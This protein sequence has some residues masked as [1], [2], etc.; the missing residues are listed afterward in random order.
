ME[1]REIRSLVALAE[2]ESIARTAQAV[3]LTPAAVHKQIKNLEAELGI[4]LYEKVGRGVRLTPPALAILPHLKELLARYDGVLSVTSDWKGLGQGQLRIGANPA[5]SGFLIPRLLRAF[6]EAWPEVTPVLEVEG[7]ATLL[8]NITNRSLDLAV[9]IWSDEDLAGV[10]HTMRWEYEVVAVSHRPFPSGTRLRALS[11]EPFVRLPPSTFLGRWVDAYLTRHGCQP[12]ETMYVS[13][14]HT[15][16]SL[17]RAGLGVG[18]LPR[19]AV[20]GEI[21]SKALHVIPVKEPR[22][23]G[24]LDLIT[25]KGGYVP[26]SVE[27]FIALARREGAGEF[28]RLVP[29]NKQTANR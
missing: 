20:A 28:L 5:I 7:S 4:P 19:W 23:V 9:G 21:A 14:S 15:M 24:M 18:L 17:V 10:N 25:P 6:R 22:L 8:H 16:I 29:V 26:R 11:K 2:L 13:S 1:F 27:S 3:N 12:T